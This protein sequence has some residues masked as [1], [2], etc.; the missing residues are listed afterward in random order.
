[1]SGAAKVA[2]LWYNGAMS[3]K[4]KIDKSIAFHQAI[5]LALYATFI[6][7]VGYIYEKFDVLGL[8][9]LVFLVSI[10]FF[11]VVMMI[12]IYF[13]LQKINKMEDL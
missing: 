5:M 10:A 4:D 11:L 7:L 2:T 9:S 1:M 3:K 6:G 13:I 12:V 8:S